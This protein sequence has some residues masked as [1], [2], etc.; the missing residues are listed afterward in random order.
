MVYLVLQVFGV[1][2]FMGVQAPK[3]S[4]PCSEANRCRVSTAGAQEA[5]LHLVRTEVGKEAEGGAW[6]RAQVS[7]LEQEAAEELS[8]V[9]WH[10]LQIRSKVMKIRWVN[11]PLASI[12]K[13]KMHF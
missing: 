7:I 9:Q 8:G 4:T 6:G 5:G 3:K 12:P 10:N 11:Q 1:C 2:V 13:S